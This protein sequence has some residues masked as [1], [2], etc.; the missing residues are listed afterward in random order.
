MSDIL[1]NK[2]LK[3]I[4]HAMSLSPIAGFKNKVT[5]KAASTLKDRL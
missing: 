1:K 4:Q 3:G 5:K 2:V